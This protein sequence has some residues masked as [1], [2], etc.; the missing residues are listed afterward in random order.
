MAVRRGHEVIVNLLLDK[1]AKF[2]VAD[3]VGILVCFILISQYLLHVKR[4]SV[5]NL[6][7]YAIPHIIPTYC[8][9]DV[10]VNC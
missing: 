2:E 5:S 6:V 1:G 3:E 4:Y 7:N 8:A 9:N 10:G